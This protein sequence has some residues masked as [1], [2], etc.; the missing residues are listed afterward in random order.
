MSTDA[1]PPRHRP[2]SRLSL[3]R[4]LK[5]AQLL[6]FEKV[7]EFGS[8][9]AASRELAMT[10]PA[11]SKSIQELERHLQAPLFVRGKRGMTLTDFGIDFEPHA[12]TM[13]AELRLMS[14]GLNAWHSGTSGH[15]V[16]GT[17]ITASSHL[18]PEAI[19]HLRQAAPD[20]TVEVRIGSNATL[21]PALSRG[22]LDVVVG[23]LPPGN[24]P[25]PTPPGVPH[26][27]LSHTTLY[28]EPLCVITDRRHPLAR[29]RKLA[30]QD[31]QA[32]DWV[33][34]TPDSVAFASVSQL[35]RQARLELP[36]RA[37][38]SVSVLTNIGLLTRSPMLALMPRS[39]VEP[40][41]KAGL[42]AI[43]PLGSLGN[44]GTVGY[45]VRT[46]RPTGALLRRFIDGLIAASGQAAAGSS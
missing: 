13:L 17:L 30:L 2:H 35:F 18:V 20:V 24:V 33:L 41:V 6:V 15:L 27:R 28:D 25:A 26:V 45:T 29:R 10:Q 31:L 42:V 40:F 34:P 43:L 7:V 32:L 39:A 22:D 46:G 3:A 4:S 44:A 36:N 11:V 12:K 8:V 19:T 37:V 16:I 1:P 5:L 21:F 23:Y 38:H 9:L 14:E